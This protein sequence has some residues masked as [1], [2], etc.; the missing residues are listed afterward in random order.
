LRQGD[1][2]EK[3]TE[4]GRDKSLTASL[5]YSFAR[6]SEKAKRHLPFLGF[7][8]ERVDVALLSLFSGN[9]DDYRQVY[10]TVFG[11]N[12]QGTDWLQI[13]NEAA[14][15]GV[16]EHL[17][18]TIY[19]IH[20]AL[21]WYLRQRL[22]QCHTTEEVSKLEKKLLI[23]YAYLAD[24]CRE[25]L[26]SDAE[27]AISTLQVEELN[28][29]Q[30][31]KL[32]EQQQEWAIAQAILQPLGEM[33]EIAGRKP[34]FQSLRLQA[35]KQIGINLTAVKPKGKEAFGFWMYL[36]NKDANEAAQS[37]NFEEAKKIYQEILDELTALNDTSVKDKI[38]IF[39]NLLGNI[40]WEQRQFD[41]AIAYYQKALHIFEAI[42][43]DYSAATVYFQLGNVA[44]EQNSFDKAAANYQKALQIFE[45][46]GDF[47]KAASSY[48]NLGIVAQQQRHFDD[49]IT[50]YRKALEIY[51]AI[52]DEYSTASNYHNLAIIAEEQGNLEDAINFYYRSL[53]IKENYKKYYSAASDYHNLGNVALKQR[54]F[55]DAI[56]Y[57]EK[58]LHLYEVIGD[59][60]N[61]TDEYVQLGRIAQEKQ[62]FDE[63]IG[64]YKKAFMNY[65]KF[66]DWYECSITLVKWGNALEAQ[67]K[68]LEA[69]QIYTHFLPVESEYAHELIDL[70]LK[71]WA[72]ILNH[73]GETQFEATWLEATSEE[74]EG[75]LRKL[76]SCTWKFEC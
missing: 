25:A 41:K 76:I 49:A 52:G 30:N 2:L 34:E 22:S 1:N 59:E 53:Q 69:L 7:F 62:N 4:E 63:A 57:Y 66:Q 3:K 16:L 8:C 72:R 37:A 40:A 55:D 67:E 11:E 12:L 46:A 39:Y 60:Y 29:L 42:G 45:T 13:L 68:W 18:E 36:R 31:L 24:E 47:Y 58:A 10:Q 19:Q 71:A 54:Q 17:S 20:P 43:D 35:L 75:E 38:A 9:L 5:D 64:Y 6:L 56:A 48:N 33:Y 61:A 27:L 14:E 23:Y 21:P 73:L 70:R 32:A 50:F 44:L 26:I 15:A 65:Q 28:L 51:E 74:C